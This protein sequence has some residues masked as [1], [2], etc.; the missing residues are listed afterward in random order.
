MQINADNSNDKFVFCL[1]CS[2]RLLFVVAVAFVFADVVAVVAAVLPKATGHYACIDSRTDRQT[3]EGSQD[4]DHD[5]QVS[6]FD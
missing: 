1:V 6:T 3:D 4:H 2:Y 5:F